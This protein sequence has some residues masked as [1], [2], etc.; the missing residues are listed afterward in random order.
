MDYCSNITF[1]DSILNL[2][3]IKVFILYLYLKMIR[4]ILYD[5]MTYVYKNFN[6]INYNNIII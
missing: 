2:L 3:Q 1:Q 4:N 6:I 5:K